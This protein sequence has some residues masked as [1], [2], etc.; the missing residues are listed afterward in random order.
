MKKSKKKKKRKKMIKMNK[1]RTIEK[2]E[3]FFQKKI[4][5]KT[6]EKIRKL[7]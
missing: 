6:I 1:K 2:N 3:I 5:E 7:K 4:G